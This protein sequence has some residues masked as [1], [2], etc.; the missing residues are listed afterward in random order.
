M[1]NKISVIFHTSSDYDYHF[2]IKWLVNEFEEKFECFGENTEKYKTFSIPIIKKIKILIK[3]VMKVF[4]LYLTKK[5][6]W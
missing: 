3:M 6:Y 2:I 4:S 5:N 1:A